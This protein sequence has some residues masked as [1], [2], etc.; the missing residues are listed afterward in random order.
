M[1]RVLTA[2]AL[3]TAFLHAAIPAGAEGDAV[4]VAS[5]SPILVAPELRSDFETVMAEITAGL[6]GLVVTSK[7]RTDADQA[8]L[9]EQGYQPHPR[10]QHKLGLAWDCVAPAKTLKLL[11]KRAHDRGL[12]AL[13]MRSPVTGARYLHVQRYARSSLAVTA[14]ASLEPEAPAQLALVSGGDPIVPV[15]MAERAPVIEP[16][17][18]IGSPALELPRRLLRRKAEGRIVLLLDLSDRGEVLD[19]EVDASNLSRFDEFVANEVRGWRFTPVT[20]DGLPVAAQA[21]FP[22]SISIQ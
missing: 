17:R 10:S 6:P 16:A 4:V 19:V 11:R 15:A 21:R 7:H 5:A 22:I 3:C 20:R 8:R 13:E 12:I 2:V 9:A 18:P 14:L 1:V